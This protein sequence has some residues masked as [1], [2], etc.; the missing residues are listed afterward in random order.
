[1]N[2][3]QFCFAKKAQIVDLA[4]GRVI[5]TYPID[6]PARNDPNAE[7]EMMERAWRYA[8][9]DGITRHDARNMFSVRIVPIDWMAY[10][11]PSVAIGGTDIDV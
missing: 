4:S 10:A 1:M 2:A 9:E 8:V 5:V 3:S 6:L 7:W 11:K